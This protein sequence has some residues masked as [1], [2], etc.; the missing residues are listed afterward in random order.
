MDLTEDEI[1]SLFG[2]DRGEDTDVADLSHW[3]TIDN[4]ANGVVIETTD[5]TYGL[6]DVQVESMKDH[7]EW[8]SIWQVISN[9]EKT[10]TY[11]RQ[12]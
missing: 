12:L 6:T 9:R 5:N 7:F 2:D 10:L 4:K 3:L 8:D 1:G 11:L